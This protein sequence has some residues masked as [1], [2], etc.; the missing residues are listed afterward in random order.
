MIGDILAK[1]IYAV[2]E[3]SCSVS[4]LSRKY[5]AESNIIPIPMIS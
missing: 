2:L 3:S 5:A 1:K 4:P